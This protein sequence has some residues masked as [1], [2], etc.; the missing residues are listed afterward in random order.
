M[1]LHRG[2]ELEIERVDERITFGTFVQ[3]DEQ[4]I[5]VQGTVGRNIG[6]EIIVPMDKVIQIVV[7]KKK[8]R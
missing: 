4:S 1:R 8:R 2:D 5:T 6:K 3:Q 7:I